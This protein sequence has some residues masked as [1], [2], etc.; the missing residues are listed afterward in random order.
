MSRLDETGSFKNLY[1][2]EERPNEDG[3]IESTLVMVYVPEAP[4]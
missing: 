2:T 1:S 4:K 3:Q